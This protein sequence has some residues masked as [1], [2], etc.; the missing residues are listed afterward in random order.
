MRL[1]KIALLWVL[2]APMTIVSIL[3]I[4]DAFGY[5]T[6]ETKISNGCVVEI[7]QDPWGNVTRQDR[8]CP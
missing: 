8:V 7:Y 3:C 1:I 6:S 2:P 5:E 4:M